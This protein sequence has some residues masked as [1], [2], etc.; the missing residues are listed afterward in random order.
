[1]GKTATTKRRRL[2]AKRTDSQQKRRQRV[3]TLKVAG[4]IRPGRIA[5]PDLLLI[6]QHV[7]SAI[8]RQAEALEGSPQTLRPG[9]ARE[10]VR[11]ECTLELAS[12]R[13]GSPTTTLG[14]ELAKPQQALPIV[15]AFGEDVLAKVAGAIESI[16]EGN[17]DDI[18]TGVLDSLNN[19]GNVFERNK[20]KSIRWIVPGTRG[21]K[22]RDVTFDQKVRR[23]V[24]ER[25][26][27]PSTR[28]SEIQGIIEMADFDVE[29]QRCR[30]HPVFGPPIQ[31]SFDAGRADDILRVMRR[32]AKIVGTATTNAQ[33][34]K[35]EVVHIQSVSSLEPLA[36]GADFFI[37]HTFDELARLQGVEPLLDISTLAGGWPDDEDPDLM[38]ADIYR[39]RG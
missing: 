21:H 28:D 17:A 14:F 3:L 11:V 5:I 30:I 13:P 22:R 18:D 38:L 15:R 36:L 10:K 16:S 35:L 23:H 33:T 19:L 7:Q 37:G 31:C 25:L 34:G 9:P 24:A 2:M 20:V 6:C 32:P 26:K 39:Q 12:V 1:M 29:H 4:Q 8:N 27:P